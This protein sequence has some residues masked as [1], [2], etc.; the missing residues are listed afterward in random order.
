MGLKGCSC[1][2]IDHLQYTPHPTPLPVCG[3]MP[4][5][6]TIIPLSLMAAPFSHS[7]RGERSLELDLDHA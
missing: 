4:T 1:I 2:V 7:P 5:F 6:S 3:Q